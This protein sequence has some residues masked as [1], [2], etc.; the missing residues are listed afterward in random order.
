MNPV[1]NQPP[2]SA[3]SGYFFM[4]RAEVEQ[5]LN[6]RLGPLLQEIAQL[7]EGLSE[8][9]D[10]KEA[11]RLTGLTAETLKVHRERPGTL[12]IV[13]PEGK[14]GSHPQYL[15]SS[16]IEFNKSRQMRPSLGRVPGRD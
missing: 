10:T 15:R 4:E 8:Y 1:A 5:L 14:T 6:D 2:P 11:K 12:I 3:R 13:K 9:V 16:L 7:K